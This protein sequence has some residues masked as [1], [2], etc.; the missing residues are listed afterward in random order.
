VKRNILAA[1]L[2]VLFLLA[3]AECKKRI[4]SEP[5]F[6]EVTATPDLFEPDNNTTTASAMIVNGAVQYHNSFTPCDYDYMKFTAS[7]GMQ[8][9]I[10]TLGLETGSDTYMYFIDSDGETVITTDDDGSP[11]PRASMITWV[12]VV[13]GAYYV[14][15]QQ[16]NCLRIFGSNT[17]YKIRVIE[18]LPYTP[19]NSPTATET[20]T[21]SPDVTATLT[22]TVSPTVTKTAF[23]TAT[24]TFTVTPMPAIGTGLW[25]QISDYSS[26]VPAGNPAAGVSASLWWYGQD[27]TGSYD[28]G[29]AN[30]GEFFAG[31]FFANAG[32]RLRFWSYEWTENLAGYDARSV[33]V[34][35]NPAG[36]WILLAEFS[37]AEQAWYRPD[38]EVPLQF[39]GGDVY[40]RFVFD[41][42]DRYHNEYKGWFVDAV[43]VGP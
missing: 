38:I 30:R 9:V 14:R 35:D 32:D 39:A 11:A 29:A 1:A 6:P 19:T 20:H 12:C 43:A 5:V 2:M 42:I 23:V 21:A 18:S 4:P 16:Y 33:F 37:G 13:S 28:T 3:A 27:I 15:I 36:N 24:P 26:S 25:H 40:F 10:E 41:T 7:A 8:Y 31:P 34:S 22:H 17:G